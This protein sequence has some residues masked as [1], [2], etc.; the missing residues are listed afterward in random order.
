MKSIIAIGAVACMAACNGW[1]GEN[2]DEW[3]RLM[4]QGSAQEKVGHYAAAAA[5]YHAAIGIVE[6]SPA[7][8]VR[9]ALALNSWARAEDELGRCSDA[10][11]LYRRA[12]DVLKVTGDVETPHYA[13]ILGNLGSLLVETGELA[14]GL[15]MLQDALTMIQRVAPA[16]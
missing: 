8:D 13:V 11:G 9:L 6:H 2:Q 1:A 15:A 14:P 10:E 12:L 3:N 7:P 5:S 16:D 4:T